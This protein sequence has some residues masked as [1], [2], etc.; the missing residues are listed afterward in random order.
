MPTSLPITDPVLIFA[1][2][3]GIFLLAP[4]IFE[5]MKVPGLIGLIFFGAV[6]GPNVLNLLARDFTFELLGQVG[7]LYLVFLAGL[8]LDL[9]R[10][11]EYRQRSIIF[12]VL[13]FGIPMGLAVGVM[14]LL[15]FSL[16]ASILIGAIIGSHTLLAYPVASR[17]GIVKNPAVITVIGGTLVTD[18]LALTVLAV[19]AGSLTGELDALFW[20]R[21]FGIL[22]VYAV[23]V[24]VAVPRLGRWF[25]R[26]VPS[27]AP[28]EFIFLMVVLFAV[29]WAAKLAGAEPII[30]AFL[31]GLTLNRLIPLNSPL[32]TRVRFV[33]NALFIPFFLLSVGMLVDPRVLVEST[34]VWTIA[35]ALVVLVHLGKFAGAWGAKL[36]FGYNREEGLTMFGLSSPQAAATLAVTFVGLEIGLFGEAVV[37]AVIIMIVVTVFVGPSLVERFGREVALQEERKPYDPSE[38]PRRILIPISNPAT[39][40]ALMDIAFLLRGKDSEEPL[41]PLMVVRG[42]EQGSEAQVAEAEKMLSHAVLY[43][44]GADV[45]VSP[46]TRVDQ[47]IAT[48]VSRALAETRTSI[49]VVGWDGRTSGSRSAVFGTVLDQLLEQSRQTVIVA[50]MGHP[51]NT[52]RR[53]VLVVPPASDR[54]P[55]FT[56]AASLM[57]RL[58]AEVDARLEAIVVGEDPA[59]YREDL[60]ALRPEHPTQVSGV[61]GWGPLLWELRT[62]LEP[63]DLVVVLSSRRGTLGWTRELEKLP[64]QLSSLVPESFL[65]VYPSEADASMAGGGEGDLTSGEPAVALPTTLEPSRIVLPAE[66]ATYREVLRNILSSHFE[67]GAELAGVLERLS[68]SEEEFSSEIRPGVALPHAMVA[69]L[70]RPLMFLGICPRG[71]RFP[72]ADNPSRAIFILLGASEKRFDHMRLLTRTA[73]MLRN[74]EEVGSLLDASEL[75]EVSEWFRANASDPETSAPRGTTGAGAGGGTRRPR[76]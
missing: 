43:A 30:G 58:A 31:A 1:L 9:N 38:A 35:G 69:G 26:N 19:V 59:L 53:I 72:N 55:G 45:P 71:I 21:L 15:G 62:Q 14:P 3:M 20:V 32:M 63:Q 65:V 51:L 50:K 67:P 2:A 11:N 52:T 40:D 60:M 12:G 57:K 6:V 25:F 75:R 76:G 17:L 7:L 56:G 39:A 13:S 44:A 34:E 42:T 36:L 28:A 16:S 23:V 54:H 66:G 29:A 47:N 24:M 41:Y 8:E 68:D 4:V 70:E 37:N 46:L 49:V 61:E 18:T 74:A 73:R 33:G 22:A 5:R 48:G 27:Q 10:F 64:G